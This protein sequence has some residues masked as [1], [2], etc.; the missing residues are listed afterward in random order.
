M[1]DI[2]SRDR[3]GV[4]CL[5]I[6]SGSGCIGVSLLSSI[7]GIHCDFGEKDSGFLEQIRINTALNDIDPSRFDIYGTDIFSGIHG[8]YDYILANP[9]YVAEDRKDEVGEDV[10]AYE[11]HIAL[12]SGPDGMDIIKVFL[13]DARDHLEEG[14]VIYMEFDEGQRDWIDNILKNNDY[15][16]WSFGND[17]FGHV[18][19]VSIIK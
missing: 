3:I 2:R 1:D 10:L 9:P 14:G 17:Q 13:S 18:R 4:R 6:F 5:D 15:S 8:K 19:F 11:P 12:F 7:K 16:S